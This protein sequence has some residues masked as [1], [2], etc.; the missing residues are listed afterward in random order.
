MDWE[1]LAAVVIFLISA[2]ILIRL[3]MDARYGKLRPSPEASEAYNRYR[4]DPN[5]NYFLSGPDVYPNALI[6]IYKDWTLETDLWKHRDLDLQSLKELV[7][8]MQLKAVERNIALHGY[9][10]LDYDGRK[11]GHWFSITGI[12]PTVRIKGGKRLVLDTPPQDT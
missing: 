3:R 2:V 6:G 9:D 5:M 8:G 7:D 10:I 11:I 1:L 12:S 4:V